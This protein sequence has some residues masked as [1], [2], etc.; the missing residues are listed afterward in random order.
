M[1]KLRSELKRLEE[2][3][4]EDV[5]Y[6]FNYDSTDYI[7]ASIREVVETLIE[8]F[9]LV[10]FVCWLFLQN[11]RTTLIPSIAIPVSLL[12]TFA[13]MMVLGYSINMF[14]LFGLVLAIG[15]VVDDAI[16]V[17][18]RVSY[19]MNAEHMSALEATRRTMKEV[20]GALIA[21]TL[22]MVAIFVPIACMSGITGKSISSL[23]LR[24]VRRWFFRQLML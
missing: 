19:L 6:V 21:A 12:A 18:E 8:T 7:Y 10:V 22:V 15:S 24:S 9:V 2:H 14:T 1:K 13:V 4:P 17:V 11:W 20:S 16:V 3:Q 23:P 5:S